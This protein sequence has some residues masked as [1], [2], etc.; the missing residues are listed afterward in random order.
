M[1]EK[2][3]NKILNYTDRSKSDIKDALI[4]LNSEFEKLSGETLKQ[5]NLELQYESQE[6]N[7][8][9]LELKLDDSGNLVLPTFVISNIGNKEA[10]LPAINF[11]VN[12]EVSNISGGWSKTNFTDL[13]Y[14]AQYQLELGSIREDL[15]VI[16]PG[17]KDRI[18]SI[19]LVLKD[20]NVKY[21]RCVF[22][23]YYEREPSLR[24]AFFIRI[25]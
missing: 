24:I 5:P 4:S 19:T 13:N 17:E 7:G 23:I 6:L 14:K 25:I 16:K 1:E 11:G 8:Q 9:T 15:S 3:E 2:V 12:E 20:Q 10:T 22:E 18:E 21:L